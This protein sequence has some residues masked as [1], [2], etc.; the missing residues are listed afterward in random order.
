MGNKRKT[1]SATA[2]KKQPTLNLVSFVLRKHPKEQL[3]GKLDR[4]YIRTSSE[5][6]IHHLKKFLG[7]KLGYS[8][9]HNIQIIIITNS[10]GG[11]T[12]S[13]Q[14]LERAKA[15]VKRQ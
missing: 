12:R 8:N 6:K 7:L 3:V 10:K 2:A 13:E 1:G 5:L 11:E 14:R 15:E 9:F 4:E